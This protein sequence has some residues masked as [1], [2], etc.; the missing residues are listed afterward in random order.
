MRSRKQIIRSI[1]LL[2]S[3]QLILGLA[4]SQWKTELGP[5]Y[6]K[7]FHEGTLQII[8][9][10]DGN[11]YLLR[12]KYGH[13][14]TFA[15]DG[16]PNLEVRRLSED[17]LS[18]LPFAPKSMEETWVPNMTFGALPVPGGIGLLAVEKTE[19]K[20]KKLCLVSYHSNE[21]KPKIERQDLAD[22]PP[23][24]RSSQSPNFRV[25]PS[26]QGDQVLISWR[27]AYQEDLSDNGLACI[28]YDPRTKQNSR[29]F[30]PLRQFTQPI[31]LQGIGLANE[32]EVFMTV[33][34]VSGNTIFHKPKIG[35]GLLRYNTLSQKLR[36][37]KLSNE[38][39]IPM[40]FRFDF[41]SGVAGGWYLNP[42]K[43]GG[44][45]GVFIGRIGSSDTLEQLRLFPFFEGT[46]KFMIGKQRNDGTFAARRSFHSAFIRDQDGYLLVLH[47]R[48]TI[49]EDLAL[50]HGSA[51]GRKLNN[52]LLCFRFDTDLLNMVGETSH[53]FYNGGKEAYFETHS[54]I[55]LRVYS[56]YNQTNLPDLIQGQT[57][58]LFTNFDGQ[59]CK[60]KNCSTVSAV[61]S[62]ILGPS[63][64]RRT[65]V[66]ITMFNEIKSDR[67]FAP[68]TMVRIRDNQWLIIAT[69]A[70]TWQLAK[71]SFDE[72]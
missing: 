59:S 22:L 5:V 42:L 13:F 25:T 71:L 4:F 43:E 1:T 46:Q 12:A 65:N 72:N 52:V 3:F 66:N 68:R 14:W 57:Y 29:L 53:G 26:P 51:N 17:G 16:E 41:T 19:G 49:P 64:E 15:P 44:E 38:R 31:H 47:L 33:K 36:Q 40:D 69:A 70:K 62:L 37:I 34:E 50:E 24:F 9:G 48:G 60:N 7:K 28:I 39:I 10:G 20:M 21:G 32:S 30:Y 54:W 6:E 45:A 35:Y 11:C 55:P 63:A 8:R 67:V 18:L 2:L 61:H 27:M 58:G 56:K 23:Y